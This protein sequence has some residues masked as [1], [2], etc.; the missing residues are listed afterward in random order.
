M[1]LG[2]VVDA[3]GHLDDGQAGVNGAQEGVGLEGVAFAARG[4]GEHGLDG[5]AAQA[6]LRVGEGSAG[7]AGEPQGGL[8]VGAEAALGHIGDAPVTNANDEGVAVGHAA[9]E[10][11]GL[12]GRVLAVG[13]DGDEGVDRLG[14]GLAQRGA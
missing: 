14:G 10:P 12:G 8:A 1:S 4:E 11:G 9:V 13:V 5:V 3:H 7:D 6:A 2:G